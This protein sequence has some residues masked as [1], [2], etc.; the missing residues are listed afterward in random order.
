MNLLEKALKQQRLQAL[1]GQSMHGVGLCDGL[2]LQECMA[3]LLQL[4]AATTEATEVLEG[5]RHEFI[6]DA[7]GTG[8]FRGGNTDQC[9]SAL[10][11]LLI[12]LLVYAPCL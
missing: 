9:L 4:L 5:E 1:S 2:D 8:S 12:L 7:M 10:H 6:Q 11:P 3:Q